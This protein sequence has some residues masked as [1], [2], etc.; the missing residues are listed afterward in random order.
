[1]GAIEEDGN[2][3]AMVHLGT[4]MQCGADGVGRNI[5]QAARRYGMAIEKDG[6]NG[7]ALRNP[8]AL[9]RAG[10]GGR[11]GAVRRLYG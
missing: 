7:M 4:L 11:T 3:G 8:E 9:E 1:M 5:G 2:V 10:L 6:N